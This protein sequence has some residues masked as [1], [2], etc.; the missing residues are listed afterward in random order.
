M[1]LWTQTI[2][3]GIITSMVRIVPFWQKVH[4]ACYKIAVLMMSLSCS[5]PSTTS[6]NRGDPGGKAASKRLRLLLID[7]VQS[8]GVHTTLLPLWDLNEI[9]VEIPGPCTI[10]GDSFN[11][12]RILMDDLVA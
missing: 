2:N 11:L 3:F 8:F 9:I 4:A 12:R 6:Q 7:L 10:L 1:W 5:P